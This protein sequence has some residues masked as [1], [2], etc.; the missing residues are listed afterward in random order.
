MIVASGFVEANEEQDVARV[1]D[2][3]RQRGFEVS[4]T[5]AEK[6]VYLIEGEN[7]GKVRSQIDALKDLPG[8]RSVY[9]TYFSLEGAEQ[10]P[11]P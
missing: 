8:V 10:E 6:V 4:E 1:V 7:A 11:A 5:R 3:L 2:S 9:L